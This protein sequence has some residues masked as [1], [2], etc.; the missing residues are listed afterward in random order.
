M[1][2]TVITGPADELHPCHLSPPATQSA[3]LIPENSEFFLQSQRPDSIL[4]VHITKACGRR[5]AGSE[6]MHGT[7]KADKTCV[8]CTDDLE[9]TMLSLHAAAMCSLR[10]KMPLIVPKKN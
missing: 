4:V 6:D 10:W 9:A 1:S 7:T 8:P 3:W 5:K 2:I